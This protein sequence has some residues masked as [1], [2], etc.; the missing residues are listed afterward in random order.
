MEIN[1]SIKLEEEKFK[2]RIMHGMKENLILSI[3]SFLWNYILN[4][5]SDP[6]QDK[7]KIEKDFINFWKENI[8]SIT[9]EQISSINQILNNENIDMINIITD[10][11]NVADIEDYQQIINESIK[12]TE[13]IFWKICGKDK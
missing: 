13:S 5:S 6:L 9:Q 3:I 12:E 4:N 11:K 8:T 10:N 1:E 2:E 7:S